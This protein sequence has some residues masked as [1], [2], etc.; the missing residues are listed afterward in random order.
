MPR[1]QVSPPQHW[2]SFR[3][4]VVRTPGKLPPACSRKFQSH[5]CCLCDAVGLER[6]REH[7]SWMGVWGRP[8]GSFGLPI[9]SA[10]S[11]KGGIEARSAGGQ[12]MPSAAAPGCSK[13]ARSTELL[14]RGCRRTAG[15]GLL[16]V[17]SYSSL[18]P[19]AGMFCI[20]FFAL[21]TDLTWAIASSRE[22][23]CSLCCRHERMPKNIFGCP[24]PSVTTGRKGI[25]CRTS[26]GLGPTPAPNSTQSDCTMQGRPMMAA[27][28]TASADGG[29]WTS[30]T[31]LGGGGGGGRVA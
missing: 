10:A 5:A 11:S 24:G 12:Q 29:G 4:R 22:H 28:G 1:V 13:R 7:A 18:T 23:H 3:Q 15:A 16:M 25:A 26:I 2:A 6:G 9:R 20:S 27:G 14:L 8:P 19:A 31:A 21:A 17:I 30:A